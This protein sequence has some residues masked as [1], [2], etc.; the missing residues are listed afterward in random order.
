VIAFRTIQRCD[1]CEYAGTMCDLLRM[2]AARVVER[3]NSVAKQSGNKLPNAELVLDC[4]TW[5][6]KGR[7]HG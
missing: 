5:W 2:E 6:R 7:G 1:T 3:M 4:A